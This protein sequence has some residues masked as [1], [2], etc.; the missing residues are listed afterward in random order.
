[1]Y[2]LCCLGGGKIKP[3]ARAKKR[4]KTRSSTTTKRKETRCVFVSEK[5]LGRGE[6]KRHT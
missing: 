6:K 5:R 2:R 3:N 4:Y 1:L